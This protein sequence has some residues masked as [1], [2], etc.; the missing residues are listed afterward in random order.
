MFRQKVLG[1]SILAILATPAFAAKL[2]DI[3]LDGFVQFEAWGTN[4][5]GPTNQTRYDSFT[6]H[7]IAFS[8]SRQLDGD[9]SFIWKLAER[10][11][12]GNFGG[13]GALGVREAW[14]GLEG[15]F[16]AIKFGR[17]LNKAW[18]VLD[19]PYGSPSYQSEPFSETGAA[20][21]VTTRAIRYG[22]PIMNGFNFETTYDVGQQNQTA[23]ARNAEIWLHYG[24][25]GLALDA[26]YQKTWET[27]TWVGVGIF[28][29]D[30]GI[31]T[32]VA[33][34]WQSMYFLGGRYT[35]SN[36]IEAILGYKKNQWHNDAGV[37]GLSDAWGG[38]KAT[39]AGTDVKA[40]DLLLGVNYPFGKW[41][42]GL[43]AQFWLGG[44]DSTNGDLNDEA[45]TYSVKLTRE[46]G[47]MT[48]LY[49]FVRHMKLDGDFNPIQTAGTWQVQGIDAAFTKSATRIGIGGQMM[50]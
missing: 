8:S 1:A 41:S 7:N 23:H 34:T 6:Q 21:W 17:F 15:N 20:N 35:F 16:G 44:E 45:K 5:Q 28:G 49:A 11:R 50:F 46:V 9:M 26:I 42:V 10:P 39:T 38:R 19:W 47:R 33:G 43:G 22:S 31:P 24:I 37:S 14:G 25:G 12:N 40:G 13:T 27:A 3:N 48:W 4:H 30:D 18:E 29:Y 32:P 36:G 2:G